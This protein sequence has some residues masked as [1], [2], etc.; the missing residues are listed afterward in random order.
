MVEAMKCSFCDQ[1]AVDDRPL[2]A[3]CLERCER[4]R[5]AKPTIV[6]LLSD[7]ADLLVRYHAQLIATGQ[8]ELAGFVGV[9][10]IGSAPKGT[11]VQ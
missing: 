8:Q 7:P 5:E 11:T 2:C 10:A 4:T 3:E 1:P 9:A 6:A